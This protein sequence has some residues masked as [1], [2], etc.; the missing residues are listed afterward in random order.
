MRA[1]MHLNTLDGRAQFSTWLGSIAINSSLMILRRKRS[2]SPASSLWVRTA[3][4]MAIWQKPAAKL[5]RTTKLQCASP[6]SL[7]LMR[8]FLPGG[9]R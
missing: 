9:L 8:R 6:L 3:F 7:A 4:S 1:Y 5:L 2:H